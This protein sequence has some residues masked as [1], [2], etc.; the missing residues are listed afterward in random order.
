MR[1][2]YAHL[3]TIY[4]RIRFGVNTRHY[5]DI[6]NDMSDNDNTREIRVRAVVKS[7]TDQTPMRDQFYY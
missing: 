5:N 3:Y 1:N 2:L 4:V 7:V 6:F